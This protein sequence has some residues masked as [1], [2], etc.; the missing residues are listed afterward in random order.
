MGSTKKKSSKKKVDV[1]MKDA[2]GPNSQ[3]MDALELQR[4]RVVCG[5]DVNLYVRASLTN[6][7]SCCAKSHLCAFPS[8]RHLVVLLITNTVDSMDHFL[9][10]S[11]ESH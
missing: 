3:I 11:L 1:E 7:L 10:K 5:P 4:T 2:S 6:T 9:W 8:C